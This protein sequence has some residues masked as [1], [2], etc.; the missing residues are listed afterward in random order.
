MEWQPLTHGY[1]VAD[2][3]TSIGIMRTDGEL[4]PIVGFAG[5]EASE[6]L[7]RNRPKLEMGLDASP[8]PADPLRNASD[9]EA[10]A[11]Q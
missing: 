2:L 9:A 8:P 4:R 7:K 11:S 3:Q 10:A 6:R 5:V 1:Q